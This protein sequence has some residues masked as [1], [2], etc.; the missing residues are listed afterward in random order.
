MNIAVFGGSF[1]P[2]HLG[3][4]AIIK[5]ALKSLHVKKLFVVPTYLN[6]FKKKFFAPSH[7]RLKWLTKLFTCKEIEILDFEVKQKRAVPTIETIE[8]LKSIYNLE[9]IY[10]VIGADNLPSLESWHR[11]SDLKNMVEFVVAARNETN[12]PKE[13][14][15]LSINAKISS[16]E[17][18][19]NMNTTFIPHKIKKEI[20]E[21]YNKEKN[22]K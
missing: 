1:D 6:P 8:Y 20:E 11:Y 2:P 15:K 17:L 14:K 10:L 19:S 16:S 9:K 3:H 12:L 21:F 18:R 13:L 4:E 22:G 5:E 7:M